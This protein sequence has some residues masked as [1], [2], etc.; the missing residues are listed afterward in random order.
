MEDCTD[1]ER[2]G[3]LVVWDK[4]HRAHD[5]YFRVKGIECKDNWYRFPHEAG[6]KNKPQPELKQMEEDGR[7]YLSPGDPDYGSER[8]VPT[9][10]ALIG[11]EA[12]D[13]IVWFS[14]T[15]H[16]NQ[17]LRVD[18]KNRIVAYVSMAPRQYLLPRELGPRVRAFHDRA[19]S[20]HWAACGFK[21]NAVP[22]T[23]TTEAHNLFKERYK[24][25]LASLPQGQET[26][27][28]PPRNHSILSFCNV[29]KKAKKD[30]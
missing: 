6:D 18:G 19:T 4:S 3:G 23:Y 17:P 1:A 26:K 13:V 30:D 2:D 21:R 15:A 11:A 29:V 9:P 8:P 12:G 22:R 7:P 16:Q 20:S 14:D 24:A 5:G 27:I 25:H 10:R 28:A